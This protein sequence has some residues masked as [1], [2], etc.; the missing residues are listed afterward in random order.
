MDPITA[1]LQAIHG[2]LAGC[3]EGSLADYIPQ[4]S[5]A[6]PSRFGL[7]V[8]SLGGQVYAA[9]D[10]YEPFTIQS[11]SKPFVYALALA[12]HG[13]D[14]ILMQVGAEPS[15]EAFNAISIDPAGR[16]ANPMIN[17]GAIV[18]TSL[19]GT[20]LV[21][22]D[23]PAKRFDHIHAGLSAFA[24][25][26]LE[27]DED[28]Y[29][30]ERRTGDR[31]R[32]LAYLM[33]AAGSLTA[34]VDEAVNTYFR[35]CSVLVTTVDIAV[36]AA[37]LANGG[38]N[39]RTG[40]RVIGEREAGLTLTVMA[41]CG[42]YDYSGEWLVRAGVP[43]KSGVSGG[44]IAA[45]PAQFGIGLYSPLVDERGNS[46][47]GVRAVQRISETFELDLTRHP[48]LT[49]PVVSLRTEVTSA[50]VIRAL[51]GEL[52]F[53]AAEVVL[54]E[55]LGLTPPQVRALVLDLSSVTHAW[56]VAVRLLAAA[57]AALTEQGVLVAAVGDALPEL[58]EVRRF[59]QRSDAVSWCL[60]V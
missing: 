4:L 17:A 51:Q 56:P 42:M 22:T 53:A 36:M 49:S 34:E 45:S 54:I 59:E 27:V 16:P 55:L 24:G 41:T 40:E 5:L 7:A 12:E 1:A 44:L 29:A 37:T 32:A 18:A 6:D 38:V 52:D 43:A 20:S 8:V 2:E 21:G 47:R 11:V 15:G 10:A 19:V 58:A 46:V 48:G 30:S 39:P 26:E 33:R 13:L 9:G 28:T 31:N 25:R 3:D 14:R 50:V 60:D 57:I 23:D 35:Q